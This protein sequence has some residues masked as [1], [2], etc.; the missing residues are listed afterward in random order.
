MNDTVTLKR[1]DLEQVVRNAL[2]LG[3]QAFGVKHK[4][5][6]QGLMEE[7][8]EKAVP[9]NEAGREY[10]FS[11]ERDE[12]KVYGDFVDVDEDFHASTYGDAEHVLQWMAKRLGV[13]TPERSAV[14][15]LR[16]QLMSDHS[17]VCTDADG[18]TRK[19]GSSEE[20]GEWVESQLDWELDREARERRERD[21]IER[22][23][24]FLLD[25]AKRSDKSS[26]PFWVFA[27]NAGW[28]FT[29]RDDTIAFLRGHYLGVI[30]LAVDDRIYA[31]DTA[32]E[33]IASLSPVVA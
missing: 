25:C 6:V 4:R 26:A 22:Q 23:R 2:R 29:N 33:A 17:I 7:A 10:G 8:E 31:Y 21:R 14:V 13:D 30:V 9:L 15:D 32:K 12:D 16:I 28:R 18:E 1:A 24:D 5:L 3:S 11:I 19:F 27:Q 20:A